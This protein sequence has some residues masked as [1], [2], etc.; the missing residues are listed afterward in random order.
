MFGDWPHDR[1]RYMYI[2]VTALV[3]PSKRSCNLL[4]FLGIEYCYLLMRTCRLAV[5][6]NIYQK[7]DRHTHSF[8]FH[9]CCEKN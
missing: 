8:V 5:G 4:I 1:S 9:H 6:A 2:F 7:T 3:V